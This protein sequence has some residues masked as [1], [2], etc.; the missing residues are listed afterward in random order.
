MKTIISYLEL[1]QLTEGKFSFT[2]VSEDSIKI[3]GKIKVLLISKEISTTLKIERVGYSSITL[4]SSDPKLFSTGLMFVPK[5][6]KKAM[7]S[8]GD[9]EIK[10]DLKSIPEL[11]EITKKLKL[12]F[13][14]FEEEEVIIGISP[15]P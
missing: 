9:G 13:L 5:N 1:S 15:R 12:D 10:I 4:S 6:L 8:L 11:S 14:K 7:V 3:S 2:Q